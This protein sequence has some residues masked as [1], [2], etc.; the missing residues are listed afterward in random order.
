VHALAINRPNSNNGKI[1]FKL[2]LDCCLTISKSLLLGTL[3]R[4]M[5]IPYR[6]QMLIGYAIEAPNER[7]TYRQVTAQ[8]A[9]NIQ[10][11]FLVLPAVGK[12]YT[13]TK[14]EQNRSGEDRIRQDIE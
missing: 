3:S 5:C 6:Q 14:W 1:E 13:V 10:R 2:L 9:A 8:L 4:K 11:S 12:S 7:E